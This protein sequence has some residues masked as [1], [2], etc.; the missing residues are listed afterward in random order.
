MISIQ[1]IRAA[2]PVQCSLREV[3]LA[4]CAAAKTGAPQYSGRMSWIVGLELFVGRNTNDG[5]CGMPRLAPQGTLAVCGGH[6]TGYRLA[7]ACVA[8]A[9]RTIPP[10]SLASRSPGAR[11]TIVCLPC[12]VAGRLRSMRCDCPAGTGVRGRASGGGP[13][14]GSGRGARLGGARVVSC[15]AYYVVIYNTAS[16]HDYPFRFV[17]RAFPALHYR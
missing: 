12:A 8:G 17:S 1:K 13:G 10:L 15:S 5:N 3:L 6:S 14:S 9:P 7:M 4:F 16:L 2:W 11:G